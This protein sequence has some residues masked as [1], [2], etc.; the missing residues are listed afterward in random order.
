MKTKTFRHPFLSD[1]NDTLLFF[2]LNALSTLETKNQ[3]LVFVLNNE[4]A[5]DFPSSSLLQLIVKLEQSVWEE[6]QCKKV[7]KESMCSLNSL[8]LCEKWDKKQMEH[9]LLSTGL[10]YMTNFVDVIASRLTWYSFPREWQDQGGVIGVTHHSLV[11]LDAVFLNTHY[12]IACENTLLFPSFQPQFYVSKTLNNLM[13]LLALRYYVKKI[14][15]YPCSVAK[16]E[17]EFFGSLK[18]SETC[19][20]SRWPFKDWKDQHCIVL[21]HPF[22]VSKEEE[23]DSKEYYEDLKLNSILKRFCNVQVKDFP[24]GSFR[25]FINDN[26]QACEGKESF[27]HTQ[28][29]FQRQVSERGKHKRKRSP[30]QSVP[31]LY[32]NQ[33]YPKRG[34]SQWLAVLL[35]KEKDEILAYMSGSVERGMVSIDNFESQIKNACYPLLAFAFETL[36]SLIVNV[37][38]LK[39]SK[40]A[41]ACVKQFAEDHHFLFG[42]ETSSDW[43]LTR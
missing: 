39:V 35:S 25:F 32:S 15:L 21:A 6:Y 22:S 16:E 11:Y 26:L 17:I 31:Q 7:G 42:K 4:F 37:H 41:A 34:S 1:P 36:E 2:P 24:G 9:C 29:L 10:L 33:T 8:H 40:D 28:K 5:K 20:Q 18:G 30:F 38:S 19:F 43:V 27:D 3:S 14:D 13:G 23:E 12:H